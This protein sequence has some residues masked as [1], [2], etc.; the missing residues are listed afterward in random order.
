MLF[1][2]LYILN[3]SFCGQV[4]ATCLHKLRFWATAY[5]KIS[6]ILYCNC[7]NRFRLSSASSPS[8][9]YPSKVTCTP[10]VVRSFWKF[11]TLYLWLPTCARQNTFSSVLIV[12]FKLN[13]ISFYIFEHVQYFRSH[14]S[15][16]MNTKR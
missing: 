2:L 7:F 1:M 9:R 3:R 15:P 12:I 11:V 16:A 4:D 13:G 5:L 8:R 10:G 6:T 14:H